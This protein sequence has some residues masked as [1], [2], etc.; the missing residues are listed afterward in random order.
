MA[1]VSPVLRVGRE[2]PTPDNG[3]S[4]SSRMPG[5]ISARRPAFSM[6][7]PGDSG[8]KL[9]DPNS[10]AGSRSGIG[11]EVGSGAC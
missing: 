5:A 8:P 6:S 10:P 1:I 9:F 4:L 2:N 11:S 3:H 7:W